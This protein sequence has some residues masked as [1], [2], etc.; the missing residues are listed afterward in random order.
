MKGSGPDEPLSVASDRRQV[1]RIAEDYTRGWYLGDAARLGRALHPDLVK[2]T[3]VDAGAS[4]RLV[5]RHN[6]WW[7]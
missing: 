6:A 2:R 7:I 5:T 1:E 4:L 3:P